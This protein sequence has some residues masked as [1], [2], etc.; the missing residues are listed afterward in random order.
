MPIAST[1]LIQFASANMPANDTGTSG[2]A[3]DATRRPDLIAFTANAVGAVVSD[4][5]D[6]RVVTI[7][8]RLA[9]GV[10]DTEA[11]TL[12]G[13]TEVAGAKTWAWIEKVEA[14]SSSATRIIT[15]RQGAAGATRATIRLNE[16]AALSLHI[17]ATSE[18]AI[19][20]RY[21]KT[22]WRNGHAT[23]SLL[24]AQVTLTADPSARARIAL[25]T[26][27]DDTGSVANRKTLPAGLTFVDDSVAANVPG[28]NLAA[29]SRI[30]VWHE[31]NLPAS[32]PA[33]RTSITTQLS[34][35]TAA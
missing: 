22:F 11:L 24:T 20:V 35:S 19:A 3:I 4:G 25:A 17:D 8:G 10:R 14:A 33:T 18:S 15:F 2:G 6:T 1:D 32:D 21:E 31:L 27:V 5:V 13:T 34:G 30:G 16:V 23:L 29:A 28:T 7:S 26:A 9:T 12:N